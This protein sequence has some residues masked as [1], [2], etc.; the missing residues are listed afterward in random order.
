MARPTDSTQLDSIRLNPLK[1]MSQLP[2]IPR[3]EV[4]PAWLAQY[5]EEALEPTLAI[6]DPH[7]HLSDTNWGGYLAPDLLDDLNSGHRI[8]ATVFI[9][10]GFAYREDGPESLKPVGETERVVQIAKATNA[11]Q[12]QTEICAGIV[13]FAE[14]SLGAQVEEVLAAQIQA[15]EG[16]MRGIRC[17]AAAHDQFQY[18]VMHAPPLHVYLNPQFREGFAKLAP[19]G[20]SFDSW[21]YHTQLPELADLAKAFP[22]TRIVIDHVGAPLGVGPYAGQRDAVFSE[23]KK[24]LQHLA[25]LPNVSVKLGGFGMSVFGFGFN[26]RPHPPTSQELAT[27]WEPYILTCIEL[28]GPERCMFE[29][30]FP[31]DKGSCSYQV[32]WNAFKRVTSGMSADEKRHLYRDTAKRFYRI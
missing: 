24:Q 3:A 22:D 18:G 10:V 16:R 7:H 11:A 9:Q 20:L 17:H 14:L 8:E 2:I 15:G 23:W 5:S 1:T 19:W 28:F 21:A 29:S 31:V 26:D 4:R 12:S 6:I 30:N 27:A 25:E 13:G 32:L